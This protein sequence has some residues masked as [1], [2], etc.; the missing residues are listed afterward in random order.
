MKTVLTFE[1]KPAPAMA[2]TALRK[3]AD[4]GK[5]S[6]RDAAHVLKKNTYIDD[7]CSVEQAIKLTGEIDKV[8]HKGG[9]H[10]KEWLSNQPLVEGENSWTNEKESE[11]KMWQGPAEEKILG[12]VCNHSEDVFLFKVNPP[13]KIKIIKR[14]ILTQIARIYDPVGAAVVFLI[15]AKIGMQKLWLEGLQC[16]QELPLQS[17]N[18]WIRFFREI[19][20]LNNVTFER[21]FTPAT[22]IGDPTLYFFRRIE[23]SLWSMRIHQMENCAQVVCYKIHCSK[24]QS[25][26]TKAINHTRS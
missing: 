2:Q 25:S 12:T 13:K 6:C 22:A 21:S 4:E 14:A 15:H 7:I 11:M 10:V 23:R 5:N 20:H 1:D 3:T 8:L 17:Q 26:T 24:I 19:K 16:D 18:G 9:F